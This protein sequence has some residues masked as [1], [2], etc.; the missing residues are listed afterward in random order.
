MSLSLNILDHLGLN[1][2]S[3]VPAVLSETVANSWDADAEK[4]SIEIS[5]EEKRI[6]I[7]DDGCGMNLSDINKRY[8]QVGYKKEKDVGRITPKGRRAMGRKGI[9]KLS[10]FSIAEKVEIQTVKDNQKHRFLMDVTE[11][12]KKIDKNEDSDKQETYYPEP[13]DIKD[14]KILRGTKII[15]TGL[16]KQVQEN[17][18]ALRKR[19]ARR[20]G[21]IGND[22]DFLVE[23][24]GNPIGANE[25]DYYHKLQ[26]IWYFGK[27]SE[28]DVER[29]KNASHKEKRP[30]K[31]PDTKYSV[32]GW[33]GTVENSG[34][35][36]EGEDNLNK[37]LLLVRGKLA[38]EDILAEFNE[39]GVYSKYIIGE[40]DADFLD[41]DE[42]EDISTTS[43]QGILEGNE[44]FSAIKK[45][46]AQELKYIQSKWTDLRNEQGTKNALEISAIQNWY[47]TLKKDDRK[48]A[49][50]LFGKINQLTVDAPDEK[51]K[52]LQFGVL[53]FESFRYKGNLD[54]LDKVSVE[55]IGALLPIFEEL[56][57]IEATLYYQIIKERIE[58]IKILKD[59]VKTDALEK[60]VQEHIFKNLWLIDTS[61]ERATGSE[62]MERAASS[63]FDEVKDAGLTKSEKSGRL[64]IKYATVWGKHVIIELKRA[65]RTL[66]TAEILKQVTKYRN[67]L[68]KLLNRKNKGHEPIEIICVVG[69]ELA[70]WQDANGRETSARILEPMNTRVVMYQELINNAYEAYKDYLDKSIE[71]G[72]VYELIKSI[73][74]ETIDL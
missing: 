51:R 21:I 36:K 45:F 18:L 46:V 9:G 6:V 26:Y 27:E 73:E 15:L 24:D 1:L 57:D 60:I 2:Y 63:E 41:S 13:L 25:R 4:V 5:P 39:G 7:T 66:T 50:S 52:L 28:A 58:V 62:F 37:I 64:D 61:W 40:I 48:R 65:K 56:S 59:K 22:F 31:I 47:K 74:D 23:V 35:L 3:N 67:G 8:L 38:V 71:A 30:S 29:A 34:A 42:E 68:R 20:F 43:R 49:E 12:R 70:D 69:T 72:R 33:I 54:S 55:E 11:I 53:A 17:S 19:L 32:S 44:R 14:V 16:K 10:L